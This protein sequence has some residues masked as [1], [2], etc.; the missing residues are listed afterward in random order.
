[1][2]LEFKMRMMYSLGWDE[3]GISNIKKMKFEFNFD[4][5]WQKAWRH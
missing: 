2:D 4:T 1:M 3:V 5:S